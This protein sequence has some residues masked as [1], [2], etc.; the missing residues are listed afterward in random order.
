MA[1]RCFL[2]RELSLPSDMPCLPFH[3]FLRC[4]GMSRRRPSR[5]SSG[6]VHPGERSDLP[7]R[8][9]RDI[10]RSPLAFGTGG[11]TGK[12]TEALEEARERDRALPISREGVPR[13]IMKRTI[14]V[15]FAGCWVIVLAACARG[16][17]FSVAF[18]KEQSIEVGNPVVL[19]GIEIGKVTGI[20]LADGKV[21]VTI[22]LDR[23]Y[24]DAIRQRSI[25]SVKEGDLEHPPRMVVHLLDPQSPPA[26]PGAR[27]EGA[28]S[29]WE[30][31][32][33]KST[34]V[35]SRIWND[36]TRKTNEF[37]Q[38]LQATIEE[39]SRSEEM[40]GM[41]ATL[42]DLARKAE[43][44]QADPQGAARRIEE[45]RRELAPTLEELYEK[46]LAPAARKLEAEFDKLVRD[47]ED[48]KKKK[49]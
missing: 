3:H 32:L 2:S 8:S 21:L 19:E 44:L 34:Q 25:L 24:A 22:R 40:Q 20:D 17:E 36:L 48:A 39:V 14:F 26:R 9:E 41:T 47:F 42:K 49:E 10:T 31:R 35:A 4:A 5:P 43:E 33:K 23:K 15:L 6:D 45:I 1:A 30:V 27:L 28:D 12:E 18:D 38:S 46:N 13:A 7:G 11:W 37:T 29:E 16:P